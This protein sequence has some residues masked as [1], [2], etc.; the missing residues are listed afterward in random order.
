MLALIDHINLDPVILHIWGGLA[1]RWYGLMYLI[2][3]VFGFLALR[4]LQKTGYLRCEAKD[5]TNYVIVGVLGVFLGGRIGYL[6]F[7]Q[8]DKIILGEGGMEVIERLKMAFAVW[9][10]GM[11]FHGGVFGVTLAFII[12]SR[13]KKHS[14][15][16]VGD[17]IVHTIPF[18]VAMVRVGN[19]INGEL[20]GRIIED[21]AGKAILDAEKLPWYAMKFP[22]E[23]HYRD[24]GSAI[25][26]RTHLQLA[27]QQEYTTLH[28]VEEAPLLG[29]YPTLPV[30]PHVW[31]SVSRFFPGRYPSQIVQFA[32][33][34]MLLLFVI[35]IVRR[36]VKRPGVLTS[37]FLM[38]YA[39]LRIPAEWIRQPDVQ[40]DLKRN[41]EGA[42]AQFLDSIG[43]T[44]GQ[45]L[46][47]VIFVWGLTTLILF[48][49]TR[50]AGPEI[51]LDVRRGGFWRDNFRE[52][53]QAIANLGKKPASK[54]EE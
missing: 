15:W 28:G 4:W 45:T 51:E 2:A 8:W 1:L 48:S 52:A 13:I 54:Q 27:L 36:W 35:W 39:I 22:T 21:E 46:S 33:E 20:Y 10:G 32:F 37:I 3:F 42:S 14:F 25:D 31:E 5:V 24:P 26:A 38:G 44:M 12:Y 19:F 40:L 16:N 7:Y 9:E 30:E 6:L 11:S 29:Q 18:G 23:M 50:L 49:K 47:V 17:A 43:M 41:A 34:G 53:R